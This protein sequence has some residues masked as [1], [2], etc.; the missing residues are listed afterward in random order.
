MKLCRTYTFI[1]SRVHC[2]LIVCVSYSQPILWDL[3]KSFVAT[4]KCNFHTSSVNYFESLFKLWHFQ[5]LTPII[6]LE[7]FNIRWR[8]WSS[9]NWSLTICYH[10]IHLWNL[11][12]MTQDWKKCGTLWVQLLLDV[13][14]INRQVV[15]VYYRNFFSNTSWCLLKHFSCKMISQGLYVKRM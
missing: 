13:L 15:Y 3:V 7:Q 12:P 14:L 2:Y 10:L 6:Y 4:R 5:I 8:W 9:K 1:G 11:M